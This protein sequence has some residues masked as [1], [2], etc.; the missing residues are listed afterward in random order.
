MK[1]FYE[2]VKFFFEQR[3][4]SGLRQAC[5]I[6]ESAVFG[7]VE[8]LKEKLEDL[9]NQV[10]AV[11]AIANIIWMIL[12][13]AL[14][15][16]E[17]LTIIGT[18][19]LGL[20]FLAIYGFIVVIQFLTLLW[21]RGVTFCHVVARAPWKRGPLQRAWAFHNENL[22]PPPDERELESIRKGPPKPRKRRHNTEHRR[23]TSQVSVSSIASTS[24][25]TDHLLPDG[26]PPSRSG[27][28]SRDPPVKLSQPV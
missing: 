21:H 15:R 20:S 27:Y 7:A 10:L 19:V 5:L 3:V 16:Q 22:P 24:Y 18:N 12:L 13:E 28:G 17:H 2:E 9:R 4:L 8:E 14:I 11:F 6:P 23:L 26:R 1:F 25:E